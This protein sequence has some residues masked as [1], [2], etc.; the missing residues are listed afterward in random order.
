MFHKYFKPADD[1]PEEVE[2]SRLQAARSLAKARRARGLAVSQRGAGKSAR[3]TRP[4]PAMR[5]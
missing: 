2:R 4:S 3:E 1:S 5:R